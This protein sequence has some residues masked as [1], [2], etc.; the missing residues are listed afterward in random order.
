MKKI[1]LMVLLLVLASGL[2]GCPW[3]HH[4]GGHGGHGGHHGHYNSR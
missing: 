2:V 4:H 1:A 3:W